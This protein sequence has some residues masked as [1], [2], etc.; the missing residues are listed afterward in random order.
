MGKMLVL[1]TMLGCV[2][3]AQTCPTMEVSIVADK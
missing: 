2:L 1:T 3:S